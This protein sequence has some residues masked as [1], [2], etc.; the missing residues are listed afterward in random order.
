MN[1]QNLDSLET[2]K[3]IHLPKRRGRPARKRE[4]E[5]GNTDEVTMS[6]EK[7][8]EE[9]EEEEEEELELDGRAEDKTAS[10]SQTLWTADM[11]TTVP[12]EEKE[13]DG[14]V[15]DQ[16]APSSPDVKALVPDEDAQRRAS[17][18][19]QPGYNIPCSVDYCDRTFPSMEALRVH[20]KDDHTPQLATLSSTP[21]K[22]TIVPKEEE[23]EQ[24]QEQEQEVDGRAEDQRALRAQTSSPQGSASESQLPTKRGQL[25]M[26]HGCPAKKMTTVPRTTDMHTTVPKEEEAEEEV[27]DRSDAQ[28][29]LRASESQQPGYNIPCS[30]DNCEFTFPSVE[31]LRVHK[32]DVHGHQ[33]APE[34]APLCLP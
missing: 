20:K 33:P 15:E 27:D 30:V 18:S 1:F 31:A 8:D 24:E 26:E 6:P 13:L 19:Q 4:T 10:W 28:R 32:K 22:K 23:Q 12:N 2:H 14:R 16:R 9:D 11:K 7:D 17:E 34:L 3:S 21:E 25:T 5:W 29:A